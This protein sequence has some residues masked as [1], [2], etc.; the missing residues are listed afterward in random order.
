[1]K[2]KEKVLFINSIKAKIMLMVFLAILAA[3]GMCM[4]TFI[5]LI[6]D[7]MQ[8]TIRYYME[9]VVTTAGSNIDRNIVLM[10][11]EATFTPEELNA[12]V[13]DIKIRDMTSSYAYVVSADGTM[14]CHPTA[15]KIGQPVENPAVNS[16]VEDLKN[17]KKPAPDVIIY[18]FN[19]S[20][21]YAAY[22]I[23]ADSDYILVATADEEEVFSDMNS[24]IKRCLESG[25]ITVVLCTIVTL[26]FAIMI[27]KP[28]EKITG[29]VSRISGFDFREDEKERSVLRKRDESGLMGRS[30]ENLRNEL[31]AMVKRIK[32]QSDDLYETSKTLSTSATE[33][34]VSLDQVEK[35]ISEVA[36]GATAQANETQTATDNV[37]LMGNMIEETNGEVEKLRSNASSMSEAG[38]TAME[39]LLQLNEVNQRTKD[40][41]QIIDKQTNVTNESAM[42]IKAAIDIITNIAEETNLLSLNAS[43]EAARAGEQG[44]GF[45]VV[46]G[47]IQKLAEQSN[48]SARQIEEII[49][50]LIAESQKSVETM[51]EVREVIETQNENVISTQRAFENVKAG[52]DSSIEGISTIVDRTAKLDEARIKVV[53]VVQNLTAI[54]QENAASTEETSASA[55]EV[56]TIMSGIAEN[57][58]RLNK[59]A[60]SLEE[61]VQQFVIE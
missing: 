1:M 53:D 35:A 59:I 50:V 49:N 54:A 41:M 34:S 20:V 30:I 28:I 57:A 22:Y 16:L 43:I 6:R 33:T 46:A 17:G 26:I 48:E 56:G 21:K 12:I 38:D 37:I 60:T 2:T 7:N 40:A 3:S 32:G 9:D 19:D 14:L 8:D 31:V 5:P 58:E 45:A 42:K 18:E 10:G 23:G 25:G 11:A 52:I 29:T 15:E 24:I 13:G 36:Q 39:I 44:R 51:E 4:W 55:A 61:S 27:V 47:Q